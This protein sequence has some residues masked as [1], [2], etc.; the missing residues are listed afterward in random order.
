VDSAPTTFASVGL[1]TPTIV[2]VLRPAWIRMPMPPT[3]P[4][5]RATR[6]ALTGWGR[7]GCSGPKTS[8]VGEVHRGSRLAEVLEPSIR[9]ERDTAVGHTGHVVGTRR[10]PA[11]AVAQVTDDCPMTPT[12]GALRA[13]VQHASDM[14]HITNKGVARSLLAE[15]KAAQSALDRGQ[16]RVAI[17]L[18]RTFEREVSALS[19]KSIEPA[20]A[21]HMVEHA[22]LV[23]Q[24]LQR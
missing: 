6:R 3:R 15:L 19:G 2:N 5:S 7:S 22:Q 14:G 18:L 16:P 17:V 23:I 10:T 1:M 24:A 13:C 21:A 8:C 11:I 20:H 12:I 4:T 9:T